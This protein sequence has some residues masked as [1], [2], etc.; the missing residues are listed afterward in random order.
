MKVKGCNEI[1]CTMYCGSTNKQINSQTKPI[2][3]KTSTGVSFMGVRFFI[4]Y[5]FLHI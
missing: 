2:M 1:N 3:A 5:F 4:F